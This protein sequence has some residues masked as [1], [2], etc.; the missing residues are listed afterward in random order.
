LIFAFTYMQSLPKKQVHDRAFS[1]VWD[2]P[3]IPTSDRISRW[4]VSGVPVVLT[5]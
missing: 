2:Q 1:N 4:V 3:G 5:S